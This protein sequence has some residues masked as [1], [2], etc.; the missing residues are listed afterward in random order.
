MSSKIIQDGL[1]HES[2]VDDVQ[3][4][5]GGVISLNGH[6]RQQHLESRWPGTSQVSVNLVLVRDVGSRRGTDTGA[7]SGS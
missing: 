5:E 7:D 3:E 1:N 2:F 6:P 4:L